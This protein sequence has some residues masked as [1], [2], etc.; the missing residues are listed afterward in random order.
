MVVDDEVALLTLVEIMLKR[1]GIT[2]LKA[3]DGYRALQLLDTRT[4][5]LFILDLMMP[6]MTG[7]E[8]CKRIRSRVETRH[9]PIIIVSAMSDSESIAQGY[10]AG[11]NDYL[12]KTRLYDLP[13]RVHSWLRANQQYIS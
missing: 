7:F 13:R 1:T 3:E 8:L 6:R 9:T 4:P 10:E 12:E 2:V 5:D 11:A